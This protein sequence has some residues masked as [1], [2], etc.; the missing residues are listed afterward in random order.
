[1]ESCLPFAFGYGNGRQDFVW[2][3]EREKIITCQEKILDKQKNLLYDAKG[4]DR[5]IN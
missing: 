5:W 2:L 4:D 3:G 1:M